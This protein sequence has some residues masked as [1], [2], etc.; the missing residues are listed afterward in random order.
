MDTTDIH[1]EIDRSFGDGPATVAPDA[2]VDELLT[3]GQR[4]VRRRRILLATSTAAALVAIVVG[5]TAALGGSPDAAGRNAPVANDGGPSNVTATGPT[6]DP[7]RTPSRAEIAS[8]LRRDLVTYDDSGNLV[9]DPDA[10]VLRRID[11]PFPGRHGDR[12]VA[13]VL[14]YRGA[15]YWLALSWNHD[16]SSGTTS[17][18]AGDARQKSFLAWVARYKG[19]TSGN[20]RVTGPDAWPGI[21]DLKAVRFV[22]DTERLEPVN[23]TTIL[24][25][26]AHVHVGDSFA[27]STDKTAAAEVKTSDGTLY[28]V[29]ARHFEGQ[30]AQYI[31]VPQDFGGASLDDF[32]TAARQRYAE[33]G[34]GLL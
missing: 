3:R 24:D 14:D 27:R 34:G 31:A 10:T 33:G 9:I 6:A 5:T 25:Q 8:A 12:S 23:G 16:G 15:T 7:T 26:R 22:G 2:L 18:W 13:M 11:N 32:L 17:M 1:D 21:P 30:S 20:D 19:M 4:V 28:Y 29:L